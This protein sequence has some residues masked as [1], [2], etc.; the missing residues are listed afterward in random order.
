MGRKEEFKTAEEAEA[1]Y[2]KY[3]SAFET[4][5]KELQKRKDSSIYLKEYLQVWLNQQKDFAYF[6]GPG[7]SI[8]FRLCYS[9]DARY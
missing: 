5:K 4:Q 3:L 7:I 2:Y 1:S 9:H 8:C 6:D